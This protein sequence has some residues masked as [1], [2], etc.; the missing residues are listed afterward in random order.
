[1]ATTIIGQEVNQLKQTFQVTE[2]YGVYITKIGLF[3][4]SVS[5][6]F[7]ITLHLRFSNENRVSIASVLKTASNMSSAASASAATETQFIFDKP[8]ALLPGRYSFTLESADLNE[9]VVWH[10]QLGDFKLGTTQERVVKDITKGEHVHV[11][12]VKTKKW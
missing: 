3:F 4:K 12:N 11:H 5:S 6:T 2:R 7:P 9:Y 8:I 1:M 10:S